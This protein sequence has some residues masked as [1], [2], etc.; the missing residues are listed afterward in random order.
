MTTNELKR[1]ARQKRV[2]LWQIADALNLSEAT[3]T[4]LLRHELPDEKQDEILR[5]I[6]RI[7]NGGERA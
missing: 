6:D 5:V 1:Y 7:A 2:F 4:R 3:V